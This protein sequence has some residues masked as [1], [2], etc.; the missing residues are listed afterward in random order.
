MEFSN[1]KNK[2]GFTLIEMMIVAVIISVWILWIVN[3]IDY[4]L[5]FVW[6]IRQE[7]IATNLAREW[8][9]WVFNI[10]DTNWTR[11]S[12]RRDEC[13]LLKDPLWEDSGCQ[14]KDRIQ[15]WYYYL[16]WATAWNQKYNKL[17]KIS[18]E[19]DDKLDLSDWL[20]WN[21]NQEYALCQSSR[22]QRHPCPNAN[23]QEQVTW[24]WRYFRMIEVKWLYNKEDW[25]SLDCEDWEDG[26]GSVD[27]WDS[28][29]KELRFCSVVKYMWDHEW[30]VKLCSAITNFRN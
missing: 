20:N 21:N 9:E 30:E 18:N 15:E 17:N 27:C 3:V 19:S 28:T 26:D 4:W 7:V 25:T 10:R 24:E 12:G 16:S 13:W 6:N 23:Q 1:I 2:S 14:N 22:W 11:W 29:P 5:K 8:I